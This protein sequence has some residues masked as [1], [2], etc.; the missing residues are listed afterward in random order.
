M[1]PAGGALS[2]LQVLN[3]LPHLA[4]AYA[5]TLEY[6]AEVRRLELEASRL[7]AESLRIASAIDKAYRLKCEELAQRRAALDRHFSA[8]ERELD[9][10]RVDRDTVRAVLERA[11]DAALAPGL[12]PGQRRSLVE[13]ATQAQRDLGRCARRQR[14]VLEDMRAALPVVQVQRRLT[15]AKEP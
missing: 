14:Q 12:A 1:S 5:R 13:L 2:L 15:S 10:L 4:Q 8:M 7:E 6:R 3:P 11:Y 9:G